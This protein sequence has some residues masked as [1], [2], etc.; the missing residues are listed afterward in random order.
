MV[1]KLFGAAAVAAIM[2]LGAPVASAAQFG[3]TTPQGSVQIGPNGVQLYGPQSHHGKL[4][5][6]QVVHAVSAQGYSDIRIVDR[7]RDVVRVR[8]EARN[9]RD[10]ILTVN[11]YT[12]RIIDRDRVASNDHHMGRGWQ[13][14]WGPDS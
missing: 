2:A 13:G 9:H 8:A 5:T 12:G 7:G 1:R 3:F 6:R 10:Y 14:G 11:A 4:S